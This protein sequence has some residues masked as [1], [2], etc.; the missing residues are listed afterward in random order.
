MDDD[1][2]IF[3]VGEQLGGEPDSGQESAKT[4]EMKP[5]NGTEQFNP[6]NFEKTILE[7]LTAFAKENPQSE[8]SAL[9]SESL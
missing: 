6:T 5:Q 4:A 1:F 7:Q 8:E 2:D 9:F 3:G